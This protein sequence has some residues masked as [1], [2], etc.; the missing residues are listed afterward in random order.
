MAAVPCALR[1]GTNN[2]LK[3]L[4]YYLVITISKIIVNI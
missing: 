1:D 2:N 3:I 4:E